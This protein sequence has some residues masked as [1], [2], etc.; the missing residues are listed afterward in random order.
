VLLRLYFADSMDELLRKRLDSDDPHLAGHSAYL[1][2]LYGSAKDQAALE[3]RLARW[4]ADWADRR[5][6]GDPDPQGMI[7]SEI[8]QSLIKSK[9]WKLSTERVNELRQSCLSKICRQ[10]VQGL[11]D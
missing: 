3:A 1:I 9:S 10:N 2:G 8:I 5:E 7:E 6:A 4:R 11:R